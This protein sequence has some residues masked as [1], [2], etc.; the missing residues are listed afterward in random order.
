MVQDELP[1]LPQTC[2]GADVLF[3]F[4]CMRL[5]VGCSSLYMLGHDHRAGAD[6]E[7]SWSSSRVLGCAC[8]LTQVVVCLWKG[9]RCKQAPQASG[10]LAFVGSLWGAN[11]GYA[12]GEGLSVLS[13]GL[14][15]F[16]GARHV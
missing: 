7:G 15:E 9:H 11:A 13:A 1:V 4:L 8:S 16:I 6:L 14:A 12:L 5:S 10:R 3:S 2:G